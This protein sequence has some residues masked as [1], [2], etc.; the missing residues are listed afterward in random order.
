[1]CAMYQTEAIVK[2]DSNNLL[3]LPKSSEKENIKF[4]YEE[5]MI[6]EWSLHLNS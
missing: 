1:M 2:T 6:F 3:S 4:N 5:Q